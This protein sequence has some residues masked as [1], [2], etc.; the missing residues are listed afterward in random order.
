MK[1]K[2]KE[3]MKSNEEREDLYLNIYKEEFPNKK[4][5]YTRN[6]EEQES[7]HYQK[8]KN[9]Y[10]NNEYED[11]VDEAFDTVEEKVKNY[12]GKNDLDDLIKNKEKEQIEQLSKSF[13]LS[14]KAI[15]EI[16]DNHRNILD[17]EDKDRYKHIEL[18]L[19]VA[20][21]VKKDN[22]RKIY[23]LLL[24]KKSFKTATELN[25]VI[26]EHMD[27]NKLSFS[28]ALEEIGDMFDI[29]MKK[30]E[31]KE[32]PKKES[33]NKEN[34][35]KKPEKKKDSI[36]KISPIKLIIKKR[37]EIASKIAER[38]REKKEEKNIEDFTIEDVSDL[39]EKYSK[40]SMMFL[41]MH[42][43]D[44]MDFLYDFMGKMKLKEDA[45]IS[46]YDKIKVKKIK[47]VLNKNG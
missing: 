15:S 12:K 20:K 19:K 41:I 31:D 46:D 4:P 34:T 16:I 22:L 1:L 28:E 10:I 32:K 38:I 3:D 7:K 21:S 35:D 27:I 9:D 37:E 23:G 42:V 39:M 30:T 45:V 5:I 11:S 18:L 44:D 6:G 2:F 33:K 43:I 26:K 13:E 25:K 17:S 36:E 24:Y 8:W 14:I 29:N 47:K 40:H